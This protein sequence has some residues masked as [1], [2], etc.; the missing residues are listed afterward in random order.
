MNNQKSVKRRGKN[1]FKFNRFNREE[2]KIPR[3]KDPENS[4]IET[5]IHINI[6][7]GRRRRSPESSWLWGRVGGFG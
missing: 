2:Q 4:N 5:I 6:I 7:C 3:T 1:R